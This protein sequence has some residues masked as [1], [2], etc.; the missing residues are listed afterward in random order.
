M[1]D[2]TLKLTHG[3]NWVDWLDPTGPNGEPSRLNPHVGAP[4]RI[5]VGTV[6]ALVIVK[7]VVGGVDGPAD[8][9]LGGRLF[10]AWFVQMPVPPGALDGIAG[11]SSVQTFTPAFPGHYVVGFYRPAGGIVHLL[12]DVK[13]AP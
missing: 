3:A 4:H 12:V 6:G 7:A 1:A 11:F 5:L 2:F 10:T 13:V 9:A 8:G